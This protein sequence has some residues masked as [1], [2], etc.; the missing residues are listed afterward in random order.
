MP[1][2]C[3]CVGCGPN[4]MRRSRPRC[5]APCAASATC[6]TSMPAESTRRTLSIGA[7][8][9]VLYTVVVLGVM[10]LFA[11]AVMWQL[12]ATF[13]AEHQ[14]FLKDKVA[15]LQTDLDGGHG[16]PGA[17]L[18]EIGRETADRG[19][20]QYEARVLAADG[21]VLGETP[22]MRTSLPIAFF[23][24]TAAPGA[25]FRNRTVGTRVFALATVPLRDQTG[26]AVVQLQIALDITRDHRLL[27]ALSHAIWLTFALLTLLLVLAGYAVSTKG[28]APLKRIVGAA[29]EVTPTR[30]SARIPTDPPWPRELA[31]L[32]WVF[33]AMLT[34]LEEAFARLSRFSADL[35]HELRTPL[36]NMSGALEVCLLRE[37][38][39]DDYRSVLESN[40]EE[41]RRLGALIDNLLFMARVER[42]DQAIRVET[43]DGREA[44]EWVLAQ[45]AQAAASRGLAIDVS[46]DARITADPVL[47]R[48]ALTNLVANA[49]L[50][51]G[52]GV[53]SSVR[54][55][56]AADEGSR[57]V[58][59]IDRGVGIDAAHLPHLFDRFYRVDPARVRGNGQGTGLGLSIV[60]TIVDL[61]GGTVDIRSARGEGTQVTLRFPAPDRQDFSTREAI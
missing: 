36:G 42:A 34:R 33:N 40:L 50:H 8:L 31:E 55:E 39:G 18:A 9:T 17:L 46:G 29:R 49:I 32:V 27:T 53:G 24:R 11:A 21:R 1:S 43:F 54:I 4:W 15:E 48:Q 41:C 14:R 51:A 30:L 60:K 38:E 16:S 3:W 10:V 7:R 6:W 26:A 59:V 58:R 25:A 20:R 35:A 5:C 47:F 57:V 2:T 61:H 52:A 22:G 13:N 45:Q 44:C 19:V 37:R 23:A 12:S 28:L 56:L